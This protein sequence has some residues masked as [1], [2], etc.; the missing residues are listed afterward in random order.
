[1]RRILAAFALAVALVSPALFVAA[2]TPLPPPGKIGDITYNNVT[3]Q[4]GLTLQVAV[5][6]GVDAG[7][8]DTY[9]AT[10]S[11]APTAYVTGGIYVLKAATANTGAATINFNGLG[12]KTI[13]PAHSAAPQA[14]ACSGCN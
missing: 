8:T 2:Q 7:S 4:E 9:V 14:R 11:P 10:I 1:M 5:N 6:Y 13:V 12:A 3:I